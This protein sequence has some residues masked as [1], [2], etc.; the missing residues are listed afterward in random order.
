[1]YPR[2]GVTGGGNRG[3]QGHVPDAGDGAGAPRAL[4]A[5]LHSALGVA[6]RDPGHPSTV[7]GRPRPRPP[8]RLRGPRRTGRHLRDGYLAPSAHRSRRAGFVRGAH[9]ARRHHGGRGIRA[10]HHAPDHRPARGLLA[11]SAGRERDLVGYGSNPPHPHWPGGARIAVNFV[12]NYEE[13]SEYNAQDDGFSEATLTEAGA[14]SYGVKGRDLAAEGLF[15][16]GS[17]VGFWRVRRIFAERR[18]PL[19]GFGWGLAVG[20]N[21]KGR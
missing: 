12:M 15:E 8:A 10:G 9:V 2:A 19:T 7:R 11:V 1:R 5:D 14:S 18:L 6:L 16:Y 17:R 3:A 20:G 13:G 21:P 4:L